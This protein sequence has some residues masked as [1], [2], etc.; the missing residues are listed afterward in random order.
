MTA[1]EIK[2]LSDED[3]KQFMFDKVKSQA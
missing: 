2:D 1:A 3:L